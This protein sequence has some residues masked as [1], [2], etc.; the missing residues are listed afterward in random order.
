MGVDDETRRVDSKG[1]VT[2]P[3]SIRRS[4]DIEPGEEVDVAL[5]EGKVVIRPNVSRDEFIESMEGCI[6]E[7]TQADDVEPMDPRKLKEDWT[8]DLP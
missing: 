2:I 4:L 3:D 7:E 5:E 6:T 8:S 1:R